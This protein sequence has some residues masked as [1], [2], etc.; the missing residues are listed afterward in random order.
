MPAH[1]QRHP[2]S[3]PTVQRSPPAAEDTATTSTCI[4]LPPATK[5]RFERLI[6]GILDEATGAVP[7]P[8]NTTEQHEADPP[9]PPRGRP[10]AQLVQALVEDE[11]LDLPMY[12][13]IFRQERTLYEMRNELRLKN[14][15]TYHKKFLHGTE[16]NVT[17]AADTNQEDLW[18]G[19]LAGSNPYGGTDDPEIPDHNWQTTAFQ[20][21]I[22]HLDMHVLSDAPE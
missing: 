5:Q 22:E 13:P 18:N 20:F 17:Y 2:P 19:F 14:G 1:R 9:N 10:Q 6:G 15:L 3:P 4:T 8:D 12:P 21:P 7:P 16:C 11:L